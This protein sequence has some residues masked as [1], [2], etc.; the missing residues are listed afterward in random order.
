MHAANWHCF[1]HPGA[2]IAR[3]DARPAILA[4]MLEEPGLNSNG[5]GQM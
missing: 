4:Y 1:L 2:W 3:A 5:S